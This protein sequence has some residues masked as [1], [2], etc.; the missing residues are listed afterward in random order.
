MKNKLFAMSL[1]LLVILVSVMSLAKAPI[2]QTSPTVVQIP[3]TS[4][5]DINGTTITGGAGDVTA[6]SAFANDN[7]LLRS[8][9]T[10]KGSQASAITV[11]DSGNTSGVGTLA[12]GALTATGNSTITGTLG[13]VTNLTIAGTLSGVT[14]ISSSGD[15]T[16]GGN[17]IY[18]NAKGPVYKNPNGDTWTDC[19]AP[20][21]LR[22]VTVSGG[23][24]T[25]DHCKAITDATGSSIIM[26][27]PSYATASNVGLRVWLCKTTST[28]NSM[29]AS[30]TEPE[31]INGVNEDVAVVQ[32]L[33]CAMCQIMDSGT[34]GIFCEGAN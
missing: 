12:C 3:G 13:G 21:A 2:W 25:A 15:H 22:A 10:G 24:T 31:K 26:T 23:L 17:T 28:G 32:D 5:K 4:I 14:T 30:G 8:D 16:A 1:I 33:G 11:D 18:A 19:P 20:T 27:F 6:A 7:R 29:T 9:G 34:I